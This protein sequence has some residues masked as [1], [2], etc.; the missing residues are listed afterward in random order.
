VL[1][2]WQ[3]DVSFVKYFPFFTPSARLGP[4]LLLLRQ[5]A[6][7]VHGRLLFTDYVSQGLSDNWQDL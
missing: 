1:S 2:R 7:F 3:A 6:G 5:S 4:L